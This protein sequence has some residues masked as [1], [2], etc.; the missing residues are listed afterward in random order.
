MHYCWTH[1]TCSS[2]AKTHADASSH[3][4]ASAGR[5]T[6]QLFVR[7]PTGNDSVTVNINYYWASV[8]LYRPLPDLL[9]IWNSHVYKQ[10]AMGKL[11]FTCLWVAGNLL[12]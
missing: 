1:N 12:R 7:L 4:W 9:H 2:I 3:Y 8:K 10:S 6:R 5:A 11:V